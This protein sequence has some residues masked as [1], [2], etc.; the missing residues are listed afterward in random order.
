MLI[1]TRYTNVSPTVNS[2]A[3]V[4]LHSLTWFDDKSSLKTN[5]FPFTSIFPSSIVSMDGIFR[6]PNTGSSY[7][8]NLT[9]FG[10]LTFLSFR[11]SRCEILLNVSFS[12][13]GHVVL[14]R[15]GKQ[16]MYNRNFHTFNVEFWKIVKC[17]I[18]R[19]KHLS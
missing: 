4:L 1:Q 9:F 2:L 18:A 13:M 16:F 15:P 6:G 19:I 3:L 12:R 17:L 14:K 11:A 7:L 10:S 8:N 5:S